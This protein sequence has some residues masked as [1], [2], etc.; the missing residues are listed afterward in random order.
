MFWYYPTRS[1]HSFSTDVSDFVVLRSRANGTAQPEYLSRNTARRRASTPPQCVIPRPCLLRGVCSAVTMYNALGLDEGT[2]CTLTCRLH[3]SVAS[4]PDSWSFVAII[5]VSFSAVIGPPQPPLVV[6][7][8]SPR[9][10]SNAGSICCFG[11]GG[12]VCDVYHTFP[13]H[14]PP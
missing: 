1:E 6:P 3:S 2:E 12:R 4:E 9:R 11:E 5:S 7:V 14:P 8:E 10:G 13:L